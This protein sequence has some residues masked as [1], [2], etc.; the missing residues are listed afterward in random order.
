[1]KIGGHSTSAGT[2]GRRGQERRFGGEEEYTGR[3]QALFAVVFFGSTPLSSVSLYMQAAAEAWKGCWSGTASKSLA[4]YNILSQRVEPTTDGHCVGLCGTS[5]WKN[6]GLLMP[7]IS[8]I[9]KGEIH[10]A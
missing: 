2:Y 5:Q 4:S 3:S 9:I 6:K 1:M 8:I 7:P 10:R